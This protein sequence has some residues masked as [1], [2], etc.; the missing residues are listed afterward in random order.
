MTDR[1][2]PIKHT[3]PDIDYIKREISDILNSMKYAKQETKEEILDRMSD[4]ESTLHSIGVGNSCLLEDL[5]TSNSTLRG[6]GNDLVSDLENMDDEINRF[7]R[8]I[9][10]IKEKKDEEIET[11]QNQILELQEQLESFY[12]PIVFV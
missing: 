5:R 6:W 1:R 2:E 8:Q 10:E 12:E 3:C 7:E 9:K 11:L 4:W